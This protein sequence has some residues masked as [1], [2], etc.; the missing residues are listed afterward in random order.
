MVGKMKGVF[1]GNEL[2]KGFKEAH[3]SGPGEKKRFKTTLKTM[4]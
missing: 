3:P 2:Q 4:N 1:G